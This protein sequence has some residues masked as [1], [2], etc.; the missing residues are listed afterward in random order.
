MT[1]SINWLSS[2]LGESSY[3]RLL[4]LESWIDIFK[5]F[6]DETEVIKN[7][8]TTII[9]LFILRLQNDLSFVCKCPKLFLQNLIMRIQ[10][11]VQGSPQCHQKGMMVGRAGTLALFVESCL[12]IQIVLQKC[13]IELDWW[14][15]WICCSSNNY[16]EPDI[17]F[18]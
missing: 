18:A 3:R 17:Q 1:V 16:M 4:R 2:Y 9:A 13:W 11:R 8:T 10:G 14:L 15:I 12:R 7:W 6:E 5:D